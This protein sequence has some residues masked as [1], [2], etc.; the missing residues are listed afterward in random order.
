MQVFGSIADIE[1][2]VG[3]SYGPTPWR[4]IDQE[5]VTRFADLT[6]DRNWIHVDI[7]RAKGGAYGGTIAHGYLTLSLIPSFIQELF[8]FELDTVRLNYGLN[9]VRFPQVVP[10]G[11]RVRASGAVRG[12]TRVEAGHQMT[13]E[14]T[15]EVE[16]RSKPACVA[17]MLVLHVARA[18]T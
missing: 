9:K 13:V 12:M 16:G 7:D 18:E 10:V 8:C 17:E 11:S 3:A 1:R 2:A 4:T 5:L 6:G 15:I 14:Y